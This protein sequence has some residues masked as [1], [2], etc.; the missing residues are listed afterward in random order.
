MLNHIR[1]RFIRGESVKFISHLDLMKVFERALRRAELPISYSH[2]FNPHPQMV[3]G[4][5]L[6]VGVTSE[7]EY[8]DFELTGMIDEQEFM[9]RLN[10]ELPIDLKI[11]EAK[12]RENKTNIMSSIIRAS[13]NLLVSIENDKII[14]ALKDEFISFMEKTS[15][16][17]KKEG[18][19]G[20][21]DVDIRPM[22]FQL[23]IVSLVELN[24]IKWVN[25]ADVNILSKDYWKKYS[26]SVIE[27]SEEKINNLYLISTVI[28]AGSANHLKP[29]LLINA[30]NETLDL[31]FRLKKIHR[32]GLWV[33]NK[34]KVY[35]P[36]DESVLSAI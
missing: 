16:I 4:L 36:M 34:G 22:V 8:A 21:R 10:N 35:N 31:N 9:N 18:K 1:V 2:G 15:I 29:G 24:N 32:T 23:D 11:I 25:L 12:K 14:D 5:P 30:I 20:L 27:N 13:Y 28:S 3:F 26:E 6:S 17:T 7:A 33:E 19:K